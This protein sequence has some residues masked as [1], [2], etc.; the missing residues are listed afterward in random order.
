MESQPIQPVG[1]FNEYIKCQKADGGAI[2]QKLKGR[3]L[4]SSPVS[5][6]IIDYIT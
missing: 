4:E 6:E 1:K 3:L 2:R 5:V